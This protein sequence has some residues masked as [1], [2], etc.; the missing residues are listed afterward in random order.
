MNKSDSIG[1]LAKALSQVQQ[2][3]KPAIKDAANPFFKS[4]YADLN[5]VWDSCRALLAE[6]GLSVAQVNQASVDGV[7]IETV[8]MHESGEWLSGEVFLPLAKHD[9]QRVGSA[10][11][12]GRRYGLS[13]IIGIVSDDDDDG[14]AA[15]QPK[16]VNK[17][18]SGKPTDMP[19]TLTIEARIG[20]AVN[21]I[22][23]LGVKPSERASGES[24][25]DY[26][27]SLNEQYKRLKATAGGH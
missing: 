18:Y 23:E 6:N 14:N 21:A 16:A 19:P 9:P 3:L 27:Q 12:Y 15:S 10:M 22:T 17:P 25:A 5:S 7:I 26:L 8:L 20:N 11:T 13:A 24:D 1:A 2:K 4:R